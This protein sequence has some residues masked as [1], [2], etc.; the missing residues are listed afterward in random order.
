VEGFD[1]QTRRSKLTEARLKS[2]HKLYN[3]VFNVRAKLHRLSATGLKKVALVFQPEKKQLEIFKPSSQTEKWAIPPWF[4]QMYAE[5][6]ASAA[7]VAS[8]GVPSP[9]ATSD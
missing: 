8:S 3:A 1:A 9:P 6:A 2:L 5:K 4:E 7:S